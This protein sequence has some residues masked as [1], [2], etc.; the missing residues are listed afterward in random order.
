MGETHAAVEMNQMQDSLTNSTGTNAGPGPSGAGPGRPGRAFVPRFMLEQRSWSSGFFANLKDFLTERPVKLPRNAPARRVAFS[1]DSFGGGFIEN[2]REW[3]R[4]LPPQ[5]RQAARSRMEVDWKPWYRAFWENLRDAIAPPKLPPLRVTSQ[6][7]KVRDIWSRNEQFRRAQGLSLAFH[8][9]LAALL[10]FPLF[11]QLA[12]T[13][14]PTVKADVNIIDIS[15]YLAQLPS[16]KDKAGGGGGGGERMNT[17]PTRGKL[18]RWSMT[19]FT[20]PM[21][22]PRNPNPKLAME[23]TLLGPP[24]LK[25][26]S[27]NLANY[28]DPLAK[29]ITGSGGPGGGGGIGTGCCG[30]I[31][32]GEGG[33][34]GPGSGGGTG[35]GVFRPGTGGVSYPTCAY[36]PTPT[37]SEEARKA[38]YQG[39]VVL[40]VIITPDGRATNIN[41]VKGP[42]LGLEEKAVEAVRTWRFNPSI[43]PNGKP[44]AVSTFIE[45]SFRLL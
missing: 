22:T 32:S 36:C 17:P 39:V 20:P 8:A 35:G 25:V 11:H 33:G 6:P 30:G 19:Q 34:L 45:V 42:G 12:A 43:G 31:G 13:A 29:L 3:L 2:L 28:G 4:P 7:V 26:P 1:Q 15:P 16:G 14:Q 38:K 21:A 27:P 10:L 37:Y 24:D 23:P 40:Q 5:A 9:L 41:V 18:P 44:V